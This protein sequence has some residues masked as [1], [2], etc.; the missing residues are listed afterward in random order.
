[1]LPRAWAWSPSGG[2]SFLLAGWRRR[3]GTWTWSPARR[4]VGDR[5]LR[6]PLPPATPNPAL[7]QPS[8]TTSKI[9][10][11]VPQP[12][13]CRAAAGV[14]P[15]AVPRLRGTS[16]RPASELPPLRGGDI[17]RALPRLRLKTLCSAV[18]PHGG[19]RS[20]TPEKTAFPLLIQR[21]VPENTMRQKG[22]MGDGG[23][24]APLEHFVFEKGK[25]R[26]GGT[27][28]PGRK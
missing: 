27:A 23:N 20:R 15:P 3:P 16:V 18:F 13:P 25:M 1:M 22:T 26:G 10:Q 6:S 7:R 8:V 12:P 2:I 9:V 17:L 28:P 24:S 5:G 11:V 19:S 14:R 21:T 4:A